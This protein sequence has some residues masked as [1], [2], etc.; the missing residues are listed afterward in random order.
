MQ[1]GHHAFGRFDKRLSIGPV[2]W[3]FFDLL[4]LHGGTAE[5]TFAQSGDVV[6]LTAPGGV[7]IL[8][9][10]HFSGSAIGNYATASVCHFSLDPEEIDPRLKG[11]GYL[12]PHPDERFHIHT[13]VRFAM[14]LAR[15]K[16]HETARRARL[17]MS[18]LDGFERPDRLKEPGAPTDR[19]A[20]AWEAAERNLHSMR[21][22]A[23]VARLIDLKESAFRALHRNTWLK[24]A[25]EHLR[26]LRLRR[27][28]ELLAT[29]GYS[30][31]EIADQVGY[32]HAET[33]NAAFRKS[34]GMTP[35]T[36]RKRANP[37]A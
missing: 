11:T 1:L 26:D 28:E 10:T 14:H 20:L 8:P 4:W 12:L 24:P 18:A 3:D 16:P 34:R 37:F 36:F 23:D 13:Q 30:L 35:G 31:V 2:K 33:L 27:A 25:G 32:G 19:L 29:T 17:L 6:L 15:Q 7:L 5:L 22:L 9:D 21:S